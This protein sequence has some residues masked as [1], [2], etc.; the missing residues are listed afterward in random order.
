MSKDSISFN[1]KEFQA[2]KCPICGKGVWSKVPDPTLFT[3]AIMAE[4]EN[5]NCG[6]PKC[7]YIANHPV[8]KS[9]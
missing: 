2:V 5:A 6:R 3:I 1:F 7:S 4:I 8:N 9:P